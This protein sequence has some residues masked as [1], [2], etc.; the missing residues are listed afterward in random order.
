MM[1]TGVLDRETFAK[2][3][4][5]EP[6]LPFAP[7]ILSRQVMQVLQGEI[8]SPLYA[9]VMKNSQGDAWSMHV[10]DLASLLGDEVSAAQAG[11]MV[12]QLGLR[13]IRTRDGYHFFW[14]LAQMEILSEAVK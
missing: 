14:N 5:A 7:E 12:R 2:V 6:R 11:R 3:L 8:D 13:S 10:K 9:Q 4:A 1:T